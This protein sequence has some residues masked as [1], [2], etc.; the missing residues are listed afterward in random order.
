M[1]IKKCFA[2]LALVLLVSSADACGRGRAQR[3]A[4]SSCCSGGSCAAS[5][6]KQSPC[7]IQGCPCGCQQGLTCTCQR[8][9]PTVQA[10]ASPSSCPGDNCR[11]PR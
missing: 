9:T 4:R 11:N 7:G 5:T 6:A 1:L 10:P 8:A 2:L 3:S